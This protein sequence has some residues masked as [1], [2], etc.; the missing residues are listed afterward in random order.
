MLPVVAGALGAV[1]AL[2][3]L[4]LLFLY[5]RRGKNLL[6]TPTCRQLTRSHLTL[7]ED[8]RIKGHYGWVVRAVWMVRVLDCVC[9]IAS[10]KELH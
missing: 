1:L 3:L 2:L 5:R 4:L 8:T 7:S 6:V 9:F 10:T